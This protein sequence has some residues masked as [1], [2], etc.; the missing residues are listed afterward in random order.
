MIEEALRHL[1]EDH[2]DLLAWFS[3]LSLLMLV[4]SVLL[5]PWLVLRAPHDVFVRDAPNDGMG[6]VPGFLLWVLRNTLGVI[7]LLAG[8]LMLVLPGQGLL[9]M[10]A[11]LCLLDIPRKRQL[12]RG[13]VVRPHIWKALGWIRSRAGKPPFDSP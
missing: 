7:L 12:L 4:G 8:I 11:A 3:L 1:W 9:T 5:V 10:V 2:A 6:S 13:I